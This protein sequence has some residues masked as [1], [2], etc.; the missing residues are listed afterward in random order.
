MSKIG[1]TAAPRLSN[2]VTDRMAG[3]AWV[4]QDTAEPAFRAGL[5][6][7]I[8]GG[9]EIRAYSAID[10]YLWLFNRTT[11][12]SPIQTPASIYINL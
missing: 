3:A 7:R 11:V 10:L 8:A 6:A 9:V 2:T 4:R 5:A 1:P 12:A